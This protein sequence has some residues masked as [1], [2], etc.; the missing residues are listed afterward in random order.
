MNMQI[1]GE[2]LIHHRTI[3]VCS[4]RS[5]DNSNMNQYKDNT[6]VQECV[7]QSARNSIT[8]HYKN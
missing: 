2:Q 7:W 1:K 4:Y 6:F 8:H 3:K 5:Q